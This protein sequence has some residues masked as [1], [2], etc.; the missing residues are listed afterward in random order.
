MTHFSLAALAH[1]FLLVLACGSSWAA[2]AA[3]P[4]ALWPTVPFIR[5]QDLCQFQDAYGKTRNELSLD[6]AHRLKDLFGAGL[7]SADAVGILMA[8]D[9]LIDK[10]RRL[11]SSGLGMDVTLEA[12]LKAAIDGFYRKINPKEK[13]L[14]FVNPAPL[15]DL[16]RDLRTEKRQGSLDLSQLAKISGFAWG[17]YAY[18]PGCRGDIMVTIHVELASGASYSFQAQGRPESVMASVG[19]QMFE[20]FQRTQFPSVVRMGAKSLTLVGAPG[21]PIGVAPS[22]AVA[23]SACVLSHARLPTFEEYEFLSALGDWNGGVSLDHQLWALADEHILAPD[24]RNPSPIRHPEDVNST[25]IYYY[26]VK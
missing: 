22:P 4:L 1:R 17:T 21:S 7:A 24:L 3:S 10:N 11:A 20:Y 6:M 13:K 25:E 16:L 18:S 12:S 19:S 9:G 15:L 2:S 8:I 5:G 26:C 14:S 23:Q